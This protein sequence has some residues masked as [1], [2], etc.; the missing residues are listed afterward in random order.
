MSVSIR[1]DDANRWQR[2]KPLLECALDLDEAQRRVYLAALADTEPELLPDLERMLGKHDDS[3]EAANT[4]DRCTRALAPTALAAFATPETVD[5]ECLGSHVGRYRLV[6]LIGA[7]GMGRVYLAECTDGSFS[8]QVALKV[9]EVS[10]WRTEI[11]D[12]SSGSGRY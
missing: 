5:E 6:R 9:V 1:P 3:V 7:G 2:I 11:F 12:A 10:R 8:Q 4:L